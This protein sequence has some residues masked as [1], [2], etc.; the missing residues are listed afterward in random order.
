MRGWV[1]SELPWLVRMGYYT[2]HSWIA[3]AL[4]LAIWRGY[5]AAKAQ[6]GGGDASYKQQSRQIALT[7]G[8]RGE[9]VKA[10]ATEKTLQSW[11]QRVH[12]FWIVRHQSSV[13]HDTLWTRC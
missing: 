3:N 2:L 4:E 10:R 1:W 12:R 7:P 5:Y 11:V 8:E 6:E 9:N 13:D